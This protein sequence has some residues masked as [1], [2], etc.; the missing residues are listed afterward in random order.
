MTDRSGAG[1]RQGHC[2]GSAPGAL[3]RTFAKVMGVLLAADIGTAGAAGI[4]EFPRF[5]FESAEPIVVIGTIA[6]GG[7]LSLPECE[8][9][10]R[11]ICM[12]TEPMWL[13]VTVKQQVLGNVPDE[14]V[15]ATTFAAMRQS[16]DLYP[17]APRLLALRTDGER[18]ILGRG[19]DRLAHRAVDGTYIVPLVH[20]PVFFLPCAATRAA[21]EINPR[22]V[23]PFMW[24]SLEE[25]E[26]MVA[27]RPAEFVFEEERWRPRHALSS[28]MLDE[29]LRD[30]QEEGAAFGCTP[31]ERK[32]LSPGKD[33]RPA[34]S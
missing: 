28:D 33:S 19:H 15:V 25:H 1:H 26:F 11:A 32:A 16:L 10:R 34:G 18:Y 23:A 27:D 14:L 29:V 24:W 3:R 21:V 17:D 9:V 5:D 30:A 2:L 20:G 7:P 31:A 22:D 8:D 12:D 6:Y 13:R 4:E